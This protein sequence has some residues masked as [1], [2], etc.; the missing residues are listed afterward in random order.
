MFAC[1]RWQVVRPPPTRELTESHKRC[2][3][4]SI[5]GI[6]VKRILYRILAAL[7]W[8]ILDILSETPCLVVKNIKV[9][10]ATKGAWEEVTILTTLIPHSRKVLT[11]SM[12]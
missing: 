6:H 5:R 1:T 10:E 3:K 4:A 2:C 9:P 7:C 8:R 11:K 12:K